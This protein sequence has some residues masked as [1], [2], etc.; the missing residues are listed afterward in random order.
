MRASLLNRS[1]VQWP[2]FSIKTQLF[3]FRP[4]R[5]FRGTMCGTWSNYAHLPCWMRRFLRR[6]CRRWRR[7]PIRRWFRTSSRRSWA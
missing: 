4:T 5:S 6:H 3:H 2:A 7:R 1:F